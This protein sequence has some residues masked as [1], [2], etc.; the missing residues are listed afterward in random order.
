MKEATVAIEDQRFYEHRGVDFQGIGRAAGPG[1]PPDGADP[2]RLDDHRAVRQ[3][4]AARPRAAGPSS[5]SSA[6]PRSPTSSSATGQGQDPHRVPERRSTSARAPT[7]SRRPP[8]PTSAGTTRAA[9][10]ASDRCASELLPWEAAMLAGIIATPTGYDPKINPQDADGAPQPGAPEHGSTRAT[11]P[12]EE[13]DQYAHAAAPEADPDPASDRALQ[14][15]LLHLLAA[16][17]AGRHAT[18]P[19]R[20]SAAAS[21]S[22]RPSTSTF[23]TRSSRSPTTRLA[24]A[25][26]RPPPSSCSTTPPAGVKAMVGGH[27]LPDPARS[28]SPPRATASRARRSSRSRWSPPSSRGISPDQVFTSAPQK[29]PLQG[30]GH[31]ARTARQQG[32]PRALRGQQLRRRVPRVSAS[33]AHRDHLLR[34]LGLLPARTSQVGPGERRRDTA[35]EDGDPDR[36]RHPDRCEVLGRRRPVRALQPGADPRR[37]AR[38][39]S[40]RS[41]WPTPTRPS[42]HNGQLVSGTMADSA[43]GPVGIQKVTDSDGQPGRAQRRRDRGR[44]RSRPSRSS[45]PSVAA[46]AQ[47]ASSHTVVTL[48][49]R[50]RTPTPATRT[51]GARPAPPRTTATPGSSAPTRTIT[52]AIWV[53]HPNSGQA[54]VDRVQRRPRRRRDDPGRASSTTIVYAPT[55]QHARPS[56]RARRKSRHRRR[57]QH[58]APTPTPATAGPDRDDGGPGRPAPRRPRPR[59]AHRRRVRRPAGPAPP[60]DL[61]RGAARAARSRRGRPSAGVGAG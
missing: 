37:A 7:A 53:G 14:G 36:P 54:D 11:S 38:P 24:G 31:E 45:R 12:S 19:A 40:P 35:T 32:R 23:R 57:P 21:R 30:E 8:R 13:Y 10:T 39:A 56:E 18:A 44:T 25:R 48:G 58:R 22:S 41:R 4:R 17:A 29:H 43:G 42:P 46:T 6:R 49:H 5:R 59:A 27:R 28:T 60:A 51:S 55:R 15:P 52:V 2:G 16:P 61:R 34:Q 33:L 3:E 26:P 50:R 20:P 9:A 47:D 1:H